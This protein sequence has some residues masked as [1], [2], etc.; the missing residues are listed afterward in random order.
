[1][2]QVGLWTSDPW[3]RRPVLEVEAAVAPEL[4]FPANLVP[5]LVSREAEEQARWPCRPGVEKSRGWE[6]PAA[7]LAL[8]AGMAREADC[9]VKARALAKKELD[10]DQIQPLTAASRPI[11]AR[12]AQA[13]AP[14]DHQQWPVFPCVVEAR[15]RCRALAR[16]ALTRV[17][18]GVLRRARIV[19]G[20]ALR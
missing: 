3:S 11:P 19:M 15:L 8:V 12:G 17:F 4:F 9:R 1:M 10:A 2:E 6:D 18:R 5:R 20:Q 16:T 13:A 7:A 14:T